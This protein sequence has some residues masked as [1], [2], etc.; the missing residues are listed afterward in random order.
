MVFY[1]FL[2]LTFSMPNQVKKD[3]SR[4]NKKR[5]M[6]QATRPNADLIDWFL[7]ID[8]MAL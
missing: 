1:A 2:R 8:V 6:E 3:R 4:P 5:E 7:A